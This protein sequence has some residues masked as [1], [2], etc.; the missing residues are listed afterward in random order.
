LPQHLQCDPAIFI[1]IQCSGIKPGVIVRE[2]S[3]IGSEKEKC[4]KGYNSQVPCPPFFI[5]PGIKWRQ[6]WN[7]AE[8]N[9]G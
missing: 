2:V 4:K 9:N 3:K 6:L 1:K 8:K 5:S 7:E